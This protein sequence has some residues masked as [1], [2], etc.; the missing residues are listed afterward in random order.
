[1][2]CIL[3]LHSHPA[4]ARKIDP[5]LYFHAEKGGSTLVSSD[6]GD[7]TTRSIT[8]LALGLQR[9]NTPSGRWAS[10]L[11][12]GMK[13]E[14]RGGDD[15]NA[16]LYRFPVEFKQNY[17]PTSYF[18]A[19]VG[20]SYHAHPRWHCKIEQYCNQSIRYKNALGI[21]IETDLVI[22]AA[23]DNFYQALLIGL[24]YTKIEYSAKN[25]SRRVDG[26]AG[27][28]TIGLKF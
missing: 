10:E 2:S 7:V 1:M 24:R 17:S 3:L 27:G 13:A 12:V 21:V 9:A 15:S 11:S 23:R 8:Y 25:D 16:E 5:I 14:G 28:F 4:S 20:A 6:Q 26:S 18:R 22:P 19:G